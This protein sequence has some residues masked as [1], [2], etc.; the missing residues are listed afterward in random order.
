MQL[1]RKG[2]RIENIVPEPYKVDDFSFTF[3]NGVIVPLTVAKDLGDTID[4][5]TNPTAVRFS[6]A[7][8]PSLLD[9]EV[10]MPSGEVTIMM[11]HVIMIEHRTRMVQPPSKEEAALFKR[12]L[13]KMPS[14]VQ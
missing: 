6:I 14:V 7:P 12:S 9:S 2:M 1:G 11:Q 8:K 3:A 13:H 10:T 4:W 5:D